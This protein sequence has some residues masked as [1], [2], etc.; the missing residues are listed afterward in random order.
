MAEA[1][2]LLLLGFVIYLE[3]RLSRLEQEVREGYSPHYEPQDS[4]VLRRPAGVVTS[5]PPVQ[6]Q[7]DPDPQVAI[8]PEPETIQESEPVREASLLH[9]EQPED[10]WRHVHVAAWN[11]VHETAFEVRPMGYQSVVHVEAA[12]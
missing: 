12:Q 7:P 8:D 5:P 10:R 1:L 3:R 11:I 4:D 6:V 9:A 2:V